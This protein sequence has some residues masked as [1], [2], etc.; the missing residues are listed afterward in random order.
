MGDEDGVDPPQL[1]SDHR[2]IAR[3]V[4]RRPRSQP[5]ID[6]HAG[7]PRADHHRVVADPGRVG[8]RP[9]VGLPVRVTGRLRLGVQQEATTLELPQEPAVDP[10]ERR[11]RRAR[12]PGVSMQRRHQ[13]VQ[14]GEELRRAFEAESRGAVRRGEGEGRRP[15]PARVGMEDRGRDPEAIAALEDAGRVEPLPE[16]SEQGARVLDHMRHAVDAGR[17][18]DGREQRGQARG[19]LRRDGRAEARVVGILHREPHVRTQPRPT[20]RWGDA[21]SPVVGTGSS[22]SNP[23]AS[24]SSRISRTRDRVPGCSSSAVS[25]LRAESIAAT[26][27]NGSP[28]RS[29]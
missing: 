1:R 16:V 26:G 22:W 15:R 17:L 4:P 9:G 21:T 13:I 6:D 29:A 14:S 2:L 7:G 5:R 24:N 23:L 19:Q 3:R 11:G 28:D 20:H 8:A 12:R 10:E 25:A 18:L 27:R